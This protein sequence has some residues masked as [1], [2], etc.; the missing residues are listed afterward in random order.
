MPKEPSD[1]PTDKPEAESEEA[2]NQLIP[3]PSAPATATKRERRGKTAPE[4]KKAA[5]EPKPPAELPLARLYAELQ[6]YTSNLEGFLVDLQLI[7]FPG[8][9]PETVHLSEL[10]DATCQAI[11]EKG[12]DQVFADIRTER[13]VKGMK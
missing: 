7:K 13:W 10:D 6:D 3:E 9:A 8:V 2:K 5:E 11:L 1:S 4:E 12:L